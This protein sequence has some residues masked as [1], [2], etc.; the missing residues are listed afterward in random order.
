MNFYSYFQSIW[1]QFYDTK[2]ILCFVIVPIFLVVFCVFALKN[3]E[4]KWIDLFFDILDVFALD[5]EQKR[6]VN[7]FVVVKMKYGDYSFLWHAVENTLSIEDNEYIK[8]LEI[9]RLLPS[10]KYKE[11]LRQH[12][13]E[14]QIYRKIYAKISRKIF[15]DYFIIIS[16]AIIFFLFFL[17]VFITFIK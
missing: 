4:K 8:S 16:I 17:S 14:Y 7:I 3:K 1:L 5:S 6:I 2:F 15:W 9:E 13:E 12:D 10:D 11:F